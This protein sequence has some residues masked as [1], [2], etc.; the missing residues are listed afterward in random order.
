MT[1]TKTDR[2]MSTDLDPGQGSEIPTIDATGVVERV[3]HE[4]ELVQKPPDLASWSSE[5]RATLPHESSCPA[6]ASLC[7]H[8]ALPNHFTLIGV[9]RTAW[10]D[11]EFRN[12]V[13]ESTSENGCAEWT[14]LVFISVM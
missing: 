3:A 12:H 8:D 11:D 14:R 5:R 13:L 2:Q 7:E 1:D 6:L 9:A 4:L 10:S